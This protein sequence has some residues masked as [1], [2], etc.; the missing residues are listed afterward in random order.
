MKSSRFLLI[1]GS[2][3]CTLLIV[4]LLSQLGLFGDT[5]SAALDSPTREEFEK[6]KAD[7]DKINKGEEQNLGLINVI[8]KKYDAETKR[9]DTR[10]IGSEFKF[11]GVGDIVASALTLE[12]FR[13]VRGDNDPNKPQWVQCDGS[14][15]SANGYAYADSQYAK[16]SGRS[17]VPNLLGRYPRGFDGKPERPLLALLEDA[18]ANHSHNLRGGRGTGWGRMGDAQ[19]GGNNEVP[20]WTDS[21]SEFA[22]S[23]VVGVDSSETRPKTTIV[24]FFIRIN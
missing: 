6:L 3:A 7:V 2:A 11:N 14:T 24:N 20:R 5:A 10:L 16:D 8:D 18:I 1:A 22:T 21:G 23:G 19:G 12:Q 9:I 4:A 15:K 17:N 13:K